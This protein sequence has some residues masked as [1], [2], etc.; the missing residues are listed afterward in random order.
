MISYSFQGGWTIRFHYTLA[1]A[2]T[3]N[4]P[5]GN[6]PAVF[7]DEESAATDGRWSGGGVSYPEGNAERA[8]PFRQ[9][10][11]G[12]YHNPEFSVKI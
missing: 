10:M 5:A 1:G 3:D 8:A 4:Y 11:G 12:V 2:G 6:R 9:G 7:A